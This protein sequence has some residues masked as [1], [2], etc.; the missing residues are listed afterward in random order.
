MRN[1]V[2]AKFGGSSLADSNQFHK[3][4]DIVMDDK[5]RRYIIPS[6]PGKRYKEDQK[7]TDLLYLCNAH[8]EQNIPF[9]DVFSIIRKRYMQLVKDLNVDI[10]IEEELNDIEKKIKNGA[11]ADYTASRGE[12]LNGLILAN[13]LDF[14]FVDPAEIIFFKE[15]GLFDEEKTQLAI[16]QRLSKIERAVIPGFYGSIKNGEIKTFSRGGSDITGAI[17][18]SG[19]NAD[20]YENWTDVSGFLMTD[21]RIVDNPKN[22]EKITYRELREL[23]YMG[24]TVLH[25]EAIFPVRKAGIPINIKNTN[26]PED[27]GTFIINDIGPASYEGTITG[28][29]GKKD[30]TVITIEKSMM[31]VEQGYCRRVLSVLE[32]NDV[33]FEHMPSGVD[34]V[35]LVISQGEL[36]G[37]LETII[38]EIDIRCNPD[39][40]EVH[41][42]MALIAIVGRGMMRTVGISA[43]VFKALAL[44]EVNVRMISQG[45]SEITI[46]VGVENNQFEKAIKAIY[47]VFEN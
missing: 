14:E 1:I 5:K 4:R 28:V 24:A 33:S 26:K 31:N 41:P 11:S 27:K 35:S 7:I 18:A 38:K 17:I 43:K 23:S 34:T 39:A 46:I 37:K 32:D 16:E 6:A 40:I 9:G 13:F 8:A 36:D 42:D 10:C 15:N 20:L 30:F 25:E 22:I 2:V 44:E 21:P 12:Y 45:S 3:V 19:V 47:S 29:A